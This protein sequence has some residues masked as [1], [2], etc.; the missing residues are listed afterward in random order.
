MIAW[1]V[2]PGTEQSASVI[3]DGV[4]ICSHFTLPNHELLRQVRLKS[5]TADVLVLEKVESFGMAVGME[6]F[7]TVFFSGM[8]AEAWF[9]SQ[10]AEMPRRIVKQHL[11]H[12][13]RATDAN[14]RQALM[15]RF[16]GML[17]IGVK[18]T[19]GPLYGLKGHEW[20]A[21]AVAITYFD[22]HGHEPI[23]ETIRPNVRGEF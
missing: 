11:C 2:D 1:G 4:S 14:I 5:P 13:A 6:V 18:K 23:G 10:V 20:A 9:P 16:G 12:T 8:C 15:D 17:S 3:F 7:R 21:F 22:Q 19:P